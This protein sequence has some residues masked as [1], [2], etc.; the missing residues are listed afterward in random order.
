MTAHR[1]TRA[2]SEMRLIGGE[3]GVF[4][5]RDRAFGCC[6]VFRNGARPY[7]VR[8][9]GGGPGPAQQSLIGLSKRKNY[10]FST[11]RI[12]VSFKKYFQVLHL[13]P[14]TSVPEHAR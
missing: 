1:T 14:L 12:M 8:F 5:P 2:N 4:L 9:L 6:P 10:F 13:C 11:Y 3:Q 7:L